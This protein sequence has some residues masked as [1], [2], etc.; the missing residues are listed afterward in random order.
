MTSGRVFRIERLSSVDGE[1]LRTVV[2]LKGCPLKCTWCSTP[3]SHRL[4]TDFGHKKDK[5]INCFACVEACP[6]GAISYDR[7][8]R[9]FFTDRHACN[10][11]LRCIQACPTSARVAH[12]RT[13]TVEALLAEV[14][15]DSIFYFHT[16]GGMTV[17]GGEPLMQKDF[18]IALLRGCQEIGINTAIETCGYAPWNTFVEVLPY[19]DALYYDLK[20]MD[21]LRHM[22]VTG[23]GNE[24]ILENLQKIDNSNYSI[25]IIIR[26]PLI[27]EI[28]D[29]DE[30][31]DAL[32]WFCKKIKKLSE[33]QVLPYHRLGIETYHQLSMSYPLAS[34]EP[35]AEEIVEK[36]VAIL[37]KMGLKVR[38]GG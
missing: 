11:C 3:E 5:C 38:V 16:G 7:S 2:F 33:I 32:G 37:K 19:L 35:H 15:R 24:L 17:S 25:P 18:L 14:Q 26:L 28:N 9:N 31:I 13:M 4:S 29:S 8:Q 30:N 34:F 12:G 22:Q 27:P 20:Q 23:V 1:G 10:D 6:L 36:K 21:R